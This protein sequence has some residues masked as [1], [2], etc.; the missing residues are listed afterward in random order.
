MPM[1][2]TL[3]RGIFV[4]A[5]NVHGISSMDGILWQRVQPVWTRTWRFSV[6]RDEGKN[7][8]CNV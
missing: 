4:Y 5:A 1:P 8:L 7:K 3:K 6:W 2:V